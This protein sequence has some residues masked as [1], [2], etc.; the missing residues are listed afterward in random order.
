MSPYLSN[1]RPREENT[2]REEKASSPFLSSPTPPPPKKKENTGARYAG[3][4]WPCSGT[5]LRVSKHGKNLPS[6]EGSGAREIKVLLVRRCSRAGTCASSNHDKFFDSQ[7]TLWPSLTLQLTYV[8][9][10]SCSLTIAHTPLP[11]DHWSLISLGGCQSDGMLQ[12]ALN[13][14]VALSNAQ[15]LCARL[16]ITWTTLISDTD[17]NSANNNVRDTVQLS[18]WWSHRCHYAFP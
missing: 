8:H 16:F 9:L 1:H 15:V 13:W 12:M 4:D 18:N 7:T 14:S 2:R 3:Y 6:G 11:G 10:D 17:Q 5:F